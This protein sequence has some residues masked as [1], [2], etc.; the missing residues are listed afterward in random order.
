MRTHCK[1]CGKEL[2]LTNEVD[3]CISCQYREL[4]PIDVKKEAREKTEYY[5]NKI[6]KIPKETLKELYSPMFDKKIC[7]LTDVELKQQIRLWV[8][9]QMKELGWLE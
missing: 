3:K 5:F 6:K 9:E 8:V 1:V 2:R 4:Y 7:E